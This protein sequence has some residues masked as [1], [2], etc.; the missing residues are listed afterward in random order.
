MSKSGEDDTP[1]HFDTV[2]VPFIWIPEDHGGP[3]PGYP[4]FEAGQM[5]FGAAEAAAKPGVDRQSLSGASGG[6]QGGT[7]SDGQADPGASAVPANA[8]AADMAGDTASGTQAVQ[9]ESL[10]STSP[11]PRS[12]GD[13]GAGAVRAAIQA[14]KALSDSG[15]TSRALDAL[16]PPNAAAWFAP[17]DRF[18][19]VNPIGP[20]EPPNGVPASGLQ[21][22]AE[23]LSNLRGKS[24]D[25]EAGGVATDDGK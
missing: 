24:A 13:A 4:W 18:A 15:V 11:P 21:A 22:Y 9:A 16:S 17:P 7:L 8:A 12:Y 6:G 23:D 1:R 14:L 10:T 25:I 2:E 5:M 3:R 20:N 19:G